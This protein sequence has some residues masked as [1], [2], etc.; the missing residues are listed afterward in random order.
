MEQTS[1]ARA[2]WPRI[3][4]AVWVLSALLLGLAAFGQS[5][6]AEGTLIAAANRADFVHDTRANQVYISNGTQILRYDV[7]TGATSALE[8]GALAG[9][10]DIS[11]DGL[12]LAVALTPLSSATPSTM[13]PPFALVS[14]FPFAR[15]TTPA[16]IDNLYGAS[17]V[18]FDN[19]GTLFYTAKYRSN[20]GSPARFFLSSNQVRPFPYPTPSNPLFI[21]TPDHE[22]VAYA[23]RGID[24]G[25]WGTFDFAR[26][27][28]V[29]APVNYADGGVFNYE[30]GVAADG[31][32]FALPHYNGFRIYNTS[33]TRL[34]L[35]GS[36]LVPPN[37]TENT[38]MGAAYNPTLPRF[39]APWSETNQV[40]VYDANTRAQIGAY[41]FETTFGWQYNA[42]F[43]KGHTRVSD[44]GSL[45]MVSVDGGVR[46]VRLAALSTPSI[47]PLKLIGDSYTL[48]EDSPLN[49]RVKS[50]GGYLSYGPTFTLTTPPQ[51]GTLTPGIGN[52]NWVYRPNPNF[53]GTDRAQFTVAQGALAPSSG[54][55]YFTIAPVNDAPVLTGDGVP[56]K[57][58]KNGYA[59]LNLNGYSVFDV[60]DVGQAF[61]PYSFRVMRAPLHGT[62]TPGFGGGFDYRPAPGYVGSDSFE[63]V[64][65]DSKAYASPPVVGL[66]S[67]AVTVQV[68][69]IDNAAPVARDDAYYNVPMYQSFT[70]PAPG[71]LSNDSDPDGDAITAAG[72]G[73]TSWGNAYISS[74]GSI[75]WNPWGAWWYFYD[76]KI[77]ITY[78]ARDALGP[79]NVA[80]I[81][82]YSGPPTV[83]AA[84]TLSTSRDTVLPIALSATGEGT[85]SYAINA[86][87]AH[88]TLSGTGADLSYTPAPG[89]VGADEFTFQVTSSSGATGT[90]KI[91]I[92]VVRPNAAPL[93]PDQSASGFEDQNIALALNASDPDGDALSYVITRQPAHGTLSGT[94]PN[95][96]YRGF[97]G[98]AGAD[99]FSYRASD[100][101]LPSREATVTLSVATVS[102]APVARADAFNATEDTTLEV[103]APG[104]TS[105]DSDAD[106]DALTARVVTQPAHGTLQ[107]RPDGSFSY[108]ADADWNGTDSFTYAAFD[109]V[110][111]S[112]PV[113][114]TIRVAAVN[115]AP[116]A[117]SQSVS[118][119]QNSAVSLTLQGSDVDGDALTFAVTR[120]PAH[121]V[122]SGTAPNLIY[123][124]APGYA[125]ADSFDFTVNDGALTSA[126]AT[127]SLTVVATAPAPVI[128]SFSPSSGAVGT[129]V[130]V[131]GS[132]FAADAV[133]KFN[134][135]ATGVSTFYSA[136]QIKVIVPPGATPGPLSVTTGGG[137]AFSAT[138][139]KVTP[140]IVSFSPSNGKIGD[141][142][143]LTG[144]SFAG[145]TAVKFNGITATFALNSPTQI[146]A[147]V[148][149]RAAT[150]KISVTTPVS[151]V[152]S[153]TNFGVTSPVVKSFSP[154]KSVVGT[155]VTLTGTNF[156]AATTVGFNGAGA[157]DL[158]FVSPTQLR[159][160]VPAAATTGQ[161]SVAN[162]D[163]QTAQST[164]NFSVIPVLTSFSPAQGAP[165]QTVVLSGSGLS[166]A[167]A[168]KFNGA[169]AVFN[170]DA[171]GHISATIPASAT[172]GSISVTT[173]GGTVYSAA[174]FVVAPRV[175]KLSPS[176]APVGGTV[177]VYGANFAA[178]CLVKFNG[179][180][181]TNVVWISSSKLTAIVPAGASNGAVS[182]TTAQG[183]SASS[184][185]VFK[186]LPTL[187]SFSP[188]SGAVASSVTLNGSGLGGATTVK[189]GSKTAT[190]NVIS[191]TQIVA[192]VPTTAKIS[193]TTPGGTATSATSFVV[194][195]YGEKVEPPNA[196]APSVWFGEI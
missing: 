1:L 35:L 45:L 5:A 76:S 60:D 175:S 51:N 39:Y 100:G 92:Q 150:G 18:A 118:T 191:A 32:Q 84:Q 148:P 17:S 104:V 56:L 187:A 140:K 126:G 27:V 117:Q 163:G 158:T 115:D 127:V 48:D 63:I 57:V 186:V 75:E 93:A 65:N 87:P 22:T 8:L 30:L 193:V 160:R 153:A 111:E 105:N 181:A 170:V 128:A 183:L 54:W 10:L 196:D 132:G 15:K 14:L 77:T 82:L 143:T 144:T 123:T 113:A 120:A 185:T 44:D 176:S 62:A 72:T 189:F 68:E 71:V 194:T 182:V 192:A 166:G 42:S 9:Q 59:F 55:V 173:A 3:L 25:G 130:T 80:T 66:D 109:G 106:G 162:P 103:A 137:T 121:G 165:L 49:I 20:Y 179:V 149:A 122:T 58:R 174:V 85:L 21:S 154:S 124:P 96:V 195:L 94:A 171:P 40:R 24:S 116:V 142:V 102:H 101:L 125:G 74:D 52:G 155:W 167:T 28:L 7:A 38:A 37:Y 145:A 157:T 161:I 190:F 131:K 79:G 184:A 107:L 112:A 119:N 99:A 135:V 70:V 81:T 46:F 98:F 151:T 114:V 110:L 31:A 53:N 178:P 133:V 69:V 83:A 146:T 152:S 78:V 86:A 73:F 164:S 41:D 97:D 29:A 180:A 91:A 61:P 2:V 138:N 139:F 136:T 90:A 172:T 156:S 159:A 34:A 36:A 168:V 11:P 129:A 4:R 19:A 33:G 108:L 134:G 43:A 12:T 23:E 88:G 95:L 64:A 13:A 16:A 188:T 177:T 147:T 141:V 67:N 169:M 89:Y 47:Y 50:A 26:G 6:R